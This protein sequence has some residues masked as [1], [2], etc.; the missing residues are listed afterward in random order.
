MKLT[1]P[2]LLSVVLCGVL[3]TSCQSDDD[4]GGVEVEESDEASSGSD[5]ETT[6]SPAATEEVTE[7]PAATA[8]PEPTPEATPSP[9]ILSGTGQAVTESFSVDG[10][11][12]FEMTHDGSSNFAIWLLDSGGNQVELLVNEIGQFAGRKALGFTG[13]GIEPPPGDY[14]LEVTADGSW[15]VAIAQPRPSSAA[16]PP[17]QLTGTGQSVPEPFLLEEGLV[18]FVLSHEGTSNFAVWLLDAFGNRVELLVNEIGTF[19][20]EA[21]IGVGDGITGA[22]PGIHYLDIAADGNWSISIELR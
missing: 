17:L 1:R 11:A 2:I 5:T 18:V 4:D 7:T 19:S 9:L 12:I 21:A 3:L 16:A 22:S 8:S 14:L 20:G 13:E 15:T 10:L 6:A